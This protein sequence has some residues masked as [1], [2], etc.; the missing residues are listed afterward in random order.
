MRSMTRLTVVRRGAQLACIACFILSV[1]LIVRAIQIHGGLDEARLGGGLIGPLLATLGVLAL[2]SVL[3]F[4]PELRTL[5]RL[6]WTSH[7]LALLLF[8]AVTGVW[9]LVGTAVRTEPGIGV[10]VNQ[11]AEVDALLESSANNAGAPA[12]NGP[13]LVPTGVSIQSLEFL[14]ANNVQVTGYVWQTYDASM[15]A[16][17][18]RG[19]VLPEAVEDA[20]QA[21]EAYRRVDAD[22]ET[23]GW[24][25]HAI[26]RQQ[27]DYRQYPFDRQD[28]WIR[29]WHADLDRNVV[30][31]PDFTAYANI[32]PTTLPGLEE[33]FVYE[34][35]DPEFTGFSIAL[36]TY[37]TSFGLD[38]EA[39]S[40]TFPELYY[41][42]GLQRDFLS[43]LL[44]HILALTVVALLLFATV[45]L[46]TMDET[47]QR[48]RGNLVFEVLRFCA[49]LL[50]VVIL[51]H[52]GI[53]SA[54]TP[55]QIAY[56]EMFPFLLYAALLLVAWNAILLTSPQPP[57]AI[58]YQDN[59]VASLLYWPLLLGALLLVTLFNLVC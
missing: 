6:H 28:V 18:T 53:R 43:P 21:E 14:S 47:H 36:N 33:Q 30:L 50:F 25:F 16:G 37:N 11:Q 54:V 49:A 46:T 23:I 12:G 31:T 1:V 56:L 20:Y 10:P 5:R 39:G 8:L 9:Y 52:N 29:L 45:R 7:T 2:G 41:N 40:A 57:R 32:D 48:R 17:V 38:R 26:L 27:F 4:R 15:P 3:V 55:D 59:I 44:D 58:A 13:Y 19:F 35:W 24:Y 22:G 42:V 51:A 34:G